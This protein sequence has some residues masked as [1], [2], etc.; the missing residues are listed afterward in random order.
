MFAV[1]YRFEIK[2]NKESEF[3]TA[4]TELTELIYKYEGS[5]GSRLH[6]KRDGV[7]IA[8]A[9]WPNKETWKNAGDELPDFANEVRVR[10]RES[11]TKIETLHELE[12][13]TDLLK[14]KTNYNKT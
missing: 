2:E 11:C 9:Q 13:I 7:Y 6:L 1:I 5:L 10:M 8:Y 14:S 12:C 4:W 3:I